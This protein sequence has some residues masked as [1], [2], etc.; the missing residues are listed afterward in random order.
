MTVIVIMLLYSNENL[1]FNCSV[2]TRYLPLISNNKVYEFTLYH[3]FLRKEQKLTLQ[4]VIPQ[5]YADGK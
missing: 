1:G 2:R 3:L 4:K 5:W